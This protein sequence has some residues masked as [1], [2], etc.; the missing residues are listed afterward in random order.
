M[1]NVGIFQDEF[2]YYFLWPLNSRCHL[3]YAAADTLLL[4]A[5]SMCKGQMQLNL[6]S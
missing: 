4:T 1:K 3:G 2:S 6:P 5:S